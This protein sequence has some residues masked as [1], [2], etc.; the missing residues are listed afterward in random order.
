MF[1]FAK[2]PPHLS[3]SQSSARIRELRAQGY[4]V[5]VKKMPNG[6][7]V[8]LRSK[9]PVRKKKPQHKKSR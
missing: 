9:E 7:E 3:K 4:E 8:I 6:D 5:E 2:S 1:G